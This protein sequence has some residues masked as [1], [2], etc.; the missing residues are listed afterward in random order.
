M[1]I[2][3]CWPVASVQ[4]GRSRSKSSKRWYLFLVCS[5][6]EKPETDT[7]TDTLLTL[8]RLEALKIVERVKGI[9]PS[10]SAWEAM[11]GGVS[12]RHVMYARMRLSQKDQGFARSGQ[13]QTVPP[14]APIFRPNGPQIRPPNAYGQTDQGNEA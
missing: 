14:V 11:A 1:R 4:E 8:G 10:L 13:F 3:V 5:C 12:G 7:L 9:E 2:V 6:S